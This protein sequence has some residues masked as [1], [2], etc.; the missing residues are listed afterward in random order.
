MEINYVLMMEDLKA[1]FR[2]TY[3]HA[4]QARP[5]RWLRWVLLALMIFLLGSALLLALFGKS[6]DQ[7]PAALFLLIP[8]GMIVLLCFWPRVITWK[9]TKNLSKRDKRRLLYSPLRIT[10]TSISFDCA[11]DDASSSLRWSAIDRI[12]ESE[13]HTF[14]FIS[15]A[16]AQIIPKRV[17]ASATDYNDFVQAMTDFFQ[18]GRIRAKP[19]GSSLGRDAASK[20][21]AKSDHA[22]RQPDVVEQ[23]RS[24]KT[25]E[26]P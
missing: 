15:S 14:V 25:P 22:S 26:N 5:I 24:P 13:D 7:V 19:D 4:P 11:S 12:E 1:Y 8:L 3:A 20:W 9:L 6:E 17:F 2:H 16:L 18:E 10:I 23:I 21:K